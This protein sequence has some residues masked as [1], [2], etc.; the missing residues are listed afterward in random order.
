MMKYYVRYNTV[1]G[2]ITG[3]GGPVESL[4]SQENLANDI[5]AVEYPLNT[6]RLPELRQNYHVVGGEV[7][8]KPEVERVA[9]EAEVTFKKY[10]AAVHQERKK[11]IAHGAPVTL[12]GYGE[13]VYLQGRDSDRAN[14]SDLAQLAQMRIGAGDFITTTVFRDRNNVD[15]SLTPA[16]IID[17]Y[18]QAA[19]LFQ[20]IM[21]T[22][23][24]LK[25]ADP[26]ITDPSQ[27]SHWP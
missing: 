18:I 1:T 27:D 6:K 12:A 16:Q 23:W 3:R 8:L 4:A 24:T 21:Q 26:E 5:S 14:I 19:A 20:A 11:R 13:T 25:K 22:S 17:L 9:A 7:V 10:R 2:E 15:H